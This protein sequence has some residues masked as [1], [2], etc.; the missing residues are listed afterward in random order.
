MCAKL[1][2]SVCKHQSISQNPRMEF[3][4]PIQVSSDIQHLDQHLEK[5]VNKFDPSNQYLTLLVEQNDSSN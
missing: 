5:Q 2:E 4:L 3:G 1:A